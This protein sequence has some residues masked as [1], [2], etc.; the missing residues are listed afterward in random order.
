MKTKILLLGDPLLRERSDPIDKIDNKKNIADY[1]VL[2]VALDEFRKENGF[3]R[4]IAAPQIGIL[5]RIIALNL[6][7]GPF[8]IINPVIVKKSLLSFSMWDD[9]MSFPDLVIRVKR[10]KTISIIYLDE[11]GKKVKWNNVEQSVSE[12]LQ[13]EIDHLNGILAIDRAISKNSILYKKEYNK[14]KEYY[15][16][17]VDYPITTTIIK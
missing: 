8:V 3:G 9:C 12:L 11:N 1:E 7:N 10:H 2:K 16:E 6:G 4:G 15:D 13:H 17:Q 14:N 5:K